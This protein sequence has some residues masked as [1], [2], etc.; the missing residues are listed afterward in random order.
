MSEERKPAPGGQGQERVVATK[1]EVSF[2]GSL[3]DYHSFI[4]GSGFT[5]LG[6][7]TAIKTGTLLLEEEYPFTFSEP[8]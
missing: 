6:E 5:M 3:V 4:K 2:L 7:N 8:Q 1:D